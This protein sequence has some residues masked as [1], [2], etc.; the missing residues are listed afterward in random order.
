MGKPELV[1]IGMTVSDIDKI[2]DFYVNYLDFT[3]EGKMTFSKDFIGAKP[4]LYKQKEGVYSDA[5]FIKSPNGIVLEL[6]QFSD[7]LPAE[8]PVWNRP[9]YHHLC[10]KVD[11]A[12]A[13]TDKMKE[14]GIELYF[15]PDPMGDPKNNNHWVF[16]RDPDGNMIELQD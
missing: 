5:A 13:I 12:K 9:G 16:L 6:F 8:E 14:G 3:L 10:I 15:E 2:V 1:H 11:N 7:P 4:Q